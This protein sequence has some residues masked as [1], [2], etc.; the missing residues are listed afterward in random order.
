M[1]A[2]KLFGIS[3]A[4]IFLVTPMSGLARATQPIRQSPAAVV[5]SA[6]NSKTGAPT[7]SVAP[8]AGAAASAA[9]LA[10]FSWLEG[11]W[12]GE[13]GP[14]VAEQVWLAPKA[15]VMEGM[16]R[17]IES[18]KTLVLEFFTLV[19][20]PDGIG[21][22]FRHFTSTLAPWEKSEATLLN[23]A[24]ID[25]KKTVFENPVDGMP[26]SAT[27]TR[28]DADTYLSRSELVPDTGDPQ[29]VEITYKRQ[30]AVAPA[31]NGGSGA[32]PKKP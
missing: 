19:Q 3:P 15:G 9:K 23:L 17:L 21:F 8:D 27:L 7:Q 2:E 28:L 16:F 20:K 18:D 32:H 31:L 11:R 13:W 25:G 6:Q 14:R 30:P 29:I 24:T 1:R 10:D 26:K 4:L 12:R 22:Y 5:S